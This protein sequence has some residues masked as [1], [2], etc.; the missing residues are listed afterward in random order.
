MTD[1]A[2]RYAK[3]VDVLAILYTRSTPLIRTIEEE[4]SSHTWMNECPDNHQDLVQ[5]HVRP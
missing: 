5:V 3:E 2:V 1:S 4:Q